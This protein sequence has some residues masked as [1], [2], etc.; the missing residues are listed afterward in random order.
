MYIW[1]CVYYCLFIPVEVWGKGLGK[2]FVITIQAAPR[3][4]LTNCI[5]QGPF[6]SLQ[7][8]IQPSEP[9]NMRCLQT[10]IW[11][12]QC[13]ES[14]RFWTMF[15]FNLIFV[16]SFFSYFLVA[17][18]G[19]HHLKLLFVA[20]FFFHCSSLFLCRRACLH[21]V[22]IKP[23]LVFSSLFSAIFPHAA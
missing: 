12:T 1:T 8:S 16:A 2:V 21:V 3:S 6:F 15:F 4:L 13:Q 23:E 11:T 18:H 14:I 22:L 19:F 5:P 17:V 9:L 10:S 20:S 7:K